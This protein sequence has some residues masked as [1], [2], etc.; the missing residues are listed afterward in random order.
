MT[1]E[2]DPRLQDPRRPKAAPVELAGKWVAWNRERTKIVT[3]GDNF[4]VVRDEAIAAG[5]ATPLM[6]VVPRPHSFIG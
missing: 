6:E 5:H 2:T 1:T 3:S 4:A